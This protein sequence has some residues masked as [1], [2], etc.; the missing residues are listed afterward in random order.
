MSDCLNCGER[1]KLNG[2]MGLEVASDFLWPNSPLCSSA[3]VKKWEQTLADGKWCCQ[4]CGYLGD[5]VADGRCVQCAKDDKEND[6]R[7]EK[8]GLYPDKEDPAN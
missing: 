5:E 7:D 2:G 8:R 6:R 4:A 3:C 1:T